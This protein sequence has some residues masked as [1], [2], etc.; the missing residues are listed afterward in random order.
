[1]KRT[2]IAAALAFC[3]IPLMADEKQLDTSKEAPVSPLVAAAKSSARNNPSKT[4]KKIVITNETLLKSGGHITTTTD[5]AQQP[6][7]PRSRVDPELDKLAAQQQKEYAAKVAAEAKAKRDLEA[8]KRAMA[9]K[10]N[11]IYEG[12]DPAGIYEDP[13]TAEARAESQ[14]PA[15]PKAPPTL[16]VQKP[17]M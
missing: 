17:P 13:S 1:M 7:P 6:L 2:S 9:E 5:R 3:A 12:D 10:A 4:K 15:T 11:A 8:K 14:S 16:Q